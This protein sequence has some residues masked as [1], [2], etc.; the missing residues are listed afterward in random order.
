M[1]PLTSTARLQFHKDFTLADAERLVP[2]F[3]RLGI[4]HFYASPLLTARA[5]STHGYDIVDHNR[6]NPE[7]GGEPA[8][9]SLVAALRKHGMGLI[10]D[11]VPNHM[12]VGGHDNAWWMDVLEWGRASPYA[13]Y[14]DID[15]DP[16]DASMRGR[17]LAPFL[18]AAYGDCLANGEFQL[19][20]DAATGR[21]YV[22]YHDHHF[23][24]NPR[25]YGSILLTEG[26]ILEGPA[27]RFTE[28]ETRD[29][30][31]DARRELRLPTYAAAIAE[32]LQAYDART[33]EGAE[34]LH[35]L[36][37]RQAYRLSWW[38]GGHRRD[39][40]APLLRRQ[41]PGRRA[42]GGAGGVRGHPSHRVP[43]V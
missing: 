2:Y 38:R 7:L 31:R 21:F 36:L 4:S 37:D 32:V 41:R 40:L 14:F 33:P 6:I 30:A 20:F 27:R 3:D 19:S 35:R 25:D 1:K 8:L 26:G 15:W 10:L 29:D 39:Q 12:G 22:A 18:G 16:A 9:E 11:I 23:P 28:L 17:L 13:E 5:G 42:G 34:R 43:P 24:V